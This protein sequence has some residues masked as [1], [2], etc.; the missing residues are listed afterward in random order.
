MRPG[1]SKKVCEHGSTSVVF[2]GSIHD[3]PL[4]RAERHTR[5]LVLLLVEMRFPPELPDGHY[6]DVSGGSLVP[7]GPEHGHCLVEA[8]GSIVGESGY[9]PCDHGKLPCVE[10]P[11]DALLVSAAYPLPPAGAAAKR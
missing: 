6:W 4:C 1:S 3:C 2:E 11:K 9:G 10:L 7:M 8:F 5:Q